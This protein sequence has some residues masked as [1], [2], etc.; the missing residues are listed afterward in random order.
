MQFIAQENT[1]KQEMN[2][3]VGGAGGFSAHREGHPALTAI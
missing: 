2:Q 1:G 3:R